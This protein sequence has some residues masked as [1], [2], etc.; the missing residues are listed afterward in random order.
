MTT[1]GNW[2][3]QPL[4]PAADSPQIKQELQQLAKA[5]D[6]FRGHNTYFQKLTIAKYP[7]K[8]PVWSQ[9]GSFFFSRT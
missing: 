2:N 1:N 9:V 7:L 8:A 6:E 3:L 5:V 4:Y